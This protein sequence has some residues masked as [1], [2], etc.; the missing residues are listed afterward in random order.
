M[1]TET[2]S[3]VF[4]DG[5]KTAFGLPKRVGFPS[6]YNGNVIVVKGGGGSSGSGSSSRYINALSPSSA[7][8]SGPP[9]GKKSPTTQGTLLNTLHDY[10]SDINNNCDYF[11][12]QD[13]TASFD[14]GNKF[15]G[16]PM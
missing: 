13:S 6:G 5:H 4:A 11:N 2:Q 12:V 7:L 3:E 15:S 1:V 16:A 10:Y 14:D 8:Q 9:P